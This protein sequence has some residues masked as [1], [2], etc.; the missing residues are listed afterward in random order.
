[1]LIF[2]AIDLFQGK[3][4]RLRQG[5]Y[6]QQT[7]YGD[8]LEIAL[9]YR[10]AGAT[11]VHLVDLDAARSGQAHSDTRRI[12]G[13][14]L[15]E[16]GLKLQIGGGIRTRQNIESWLDAGVWR[17]VLGTAAVKN[18]EF[19]CEMVQMFGLQV[20]VGI[21]AKD[22]FVATQGWV[23]TQDIT[24][25]EF[26]SKMA[27]CGLQECIYTDIGK[28]GMLTGAN[29]EASIELAKV[30]GLSVIVSGGVRDLEDVRKIAALHSDGLGGLIAGKSLYEGTL[31]LREA[32][33]TAEKLDGLH[34]VV[35]R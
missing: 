32:L 9:R 3:A 19:A 24:A 35:D 5:D 22:G 25:Q 33:L 29:I 17:C 2:P 1:M 8:P 15:E 13:A 31:D 7:I 18:P 27:A 6:D 10:E 34:R 4:V 16:T 26:A 11:H 12:V 30:S 28:D 21:D 14:I 20:T 23:E